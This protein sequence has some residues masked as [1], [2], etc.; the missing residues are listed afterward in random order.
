MHHFNGS[1]TSLQDAEVLH[2]KPMPL[3]VRVIVIVGAL[4]TLMGAVIALVHPVML[5]APRD[6]INRAVRIY[7][8]YLATRNLTLAV[9]LMALLLVGARRSLGNLM[10]LVGLIQVLDACMDVYERR[11]AI[12][13][14]VL[15]FGL[16]FLIGAA[17]LSDGNPFWKLKAWTQ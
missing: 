7:A 2:S 15:A 5:V 13:P 1:S 4:L 14:G 12:V 8:G 9:L 3:W 16:I 6:E 10:V 11:W 17:R